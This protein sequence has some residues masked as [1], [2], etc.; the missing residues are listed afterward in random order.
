MPGL[1]QPCPM[2]AACWS[3]AMPRMRIG[4]AEQF[5][6]AL[7]RTRRRSRATCGSI[8][9]GT[10][11]SAAQLFVPLAAA[12]IEQQRARGIAGVGRVHLAAGQ[13]PQQKRIDGAEGEPARLAAAA[14]APST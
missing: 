14:R 9:A 8:G 1:K 11:N 12:D 3:P 6:A 5:A 7:R 13:P 2:V 4:A 10:P